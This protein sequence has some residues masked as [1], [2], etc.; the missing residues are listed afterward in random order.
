MSKGLFIVIEGGDGTGKST[1]IRLMAEKL[2]DIGREVVITREPG[3][4][5]ISEEIRKIILRT[6]FMEM[7]D[8]TEALLYAASRAQHVHEL[9]RP[10]LE[11]GAVVI[12][13]RYV[14]SSIV[15]QG[16]ARGLGEDAVRA[17]NDFG[18]KKLKADLTIILTLDASKGIARKKEERVLDRLE[19]QKLMFHKKVQHGF[20][21]LK[22]KD[23]TYISIN[24]ALSIDEIHQK[25]GKRVDALLKSSQRVEVAN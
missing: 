25:I 22:G 10:S 2:K 4:T 19:M 7:S 18:T 13:D 16:Y 24:A 6:D 3:G 8:E 17:V 1:Q 9:I 23:E 11:R 15:Y 20:K 14:D 5:L 12:C 21:M